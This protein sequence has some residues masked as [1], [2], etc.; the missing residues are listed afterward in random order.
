MFENMTKR[1]KMLAAVVAALVPIG[2]LFFGFMWFMDKVEAN[3]LE[4]DTLASAVE[5]QEDLEFQAAKAKIRR[6]FYRTISIP[7][8][9]NDA[10][11]QYSTWLSN[12]AARNSMEAFEFGQAA[13]QARN[14]KDNKVFDPVTYRISF[15][16]TL[17]NFANLLYDFETA[18]ILHRIRS[19]TVNP[20]NR[21]ADAGADSSYSKGLLKIN[22]EVDVLSLVDADG[23][24][25]LDQLKI[26]PDSFISFRDRRE[27][28]SA[29]EYKQKVLGTIAGRNIFS[30]GNSPPVFETV[31]A[32]V[33]A[34]QKIS[35]SIEADDPDNKDRLLFE[36]I[37]SELSEPEIKQATPKAKRINFSA[38]AAEIGTYKVVVRA[39][40]NGNPR[41]STDQEIL[42][43]VVEKANSKPRFTEKDFEVACR[44]PIS[45]PLEVTDD[46]EGDEVEF[47]ILDSDLDG[48]E[49][50]LDED[51]GLKATL[52]ASA[53]EPGEYR[54]R[55]EA[56]DKAMLKAAQESE[57]DQSASGS[58]SG[59]RRNEENGDEENGDEEN[60]DEIE[61]PRSGGVP[62]ML[63]VEV[64][65][66][67][68]FEAEATV[69]YRD[70]RKN[71][72]DYVGIHI[73]TQGK[74]LLLATGESFELD[75]KTWTVE[76]I[77]LE[78]H[79]LVLRVNEKLCLYK[80]GDALSKP[81]SQT[82]LT[83]VD[84][85]EEPE[86]D[87]ADPDSIDETGSVPAIGEN[88]EGDSSGLETPEAET[89]R[90]G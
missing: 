55:V 86:G 90:A 18:A 77:S 24:R 79:E 7:S 10:K 51:D 80:F 13:G 17:E 66:P 61:R 72:T 40:D 12:L 70:W 73:R 63:T 67:S 1:E 25:D 60:D 28:Q 85:S 82:E 81:R 39:T 44:Q 30:P 45:I 42:I 46:D 29:E 68:F 41:K 38:A 56:L 11:E 69:Y 19:L 37:S 22:M 34:G 8:N 47:R 43:N 52:I 2:M 87:L 49:I 59:T 57:G 78:R 14:F 3:Y 65:A 88:S 20:P 9:L 21:T 6:E 75:D 23:A 76:S 84:S 32:E 5:A 35:F 4:M 33:T 48:A 64:T 71:G 16:G 15:D 27:D 89:D 31:D 83:A 26:P 54:V 58:E 62:A 74:R 53:A 50:V 36:L